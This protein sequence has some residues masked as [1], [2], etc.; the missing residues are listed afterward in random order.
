MSAASELRTLLIVSH[1][2]HFRYG[3]R[4][5]AYSPYAREIDIWADLFP[6]I[7][8]A[9][10]CRSEPPDKDCA[11][12]TRSNIDVIPQPE[13]GG[14]TWRAKL[15]QL[16]SLPRLIRE[17]GRA[18]R[19]GDAIQVRCP[20]N[21]GLLGTILAPLH[22]RFLVAKYTGQWNGFPGEAW[23]WKFQRWLLRS[24][25][26]RGPVTVYGQWPN[27]PQK[28]VP[29]FTSVMTDQQMRRARHS[30]QM[31]KLEA[32][33]KILY[34]GRLT[35]AKN[36]DILLQALANLKARSLTAH[37]RIVGEGPERSALQAL[38]DR[39]KL[40]DC[41][42]FMGGVD[43]E[44]VLGFYEQSDV[45]VLAS[46]TESWGKSIT[47]AMAFGLVCVGS[48]R[49]LMPEMLA[50]DRG[51][52]VP[53]RDVDALTNI[54]AQIAAAPETFQEM[55]NR[56]ASWGQQY[57]LESLRE[58]FRSTLAKHW[59]VPLE[60]SPQVLDSTVGACVR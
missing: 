11:A 33:V 31:R 47:E 7:R 46:N 4:L 43:F 22:S 15:A 28:I 55:S 9:A 48:N 60:V 10:P 25:W 39:L 14:D 5:Y 13:T 20:G 59:H 45:L 57:S 29:L 23:S 50:D 12:F 21:L 6:H 41:V 24:G 58:A 37:C 3:D 40:E 49:G 44:N 52:V 18:M 36:V 27:Q 42:Q 54:L 34:V 32:P 26:W 2:V 51:F 30:A 35:R 17:L 8:I 19:K 53:P 16:L 1:V 38:C 56:A